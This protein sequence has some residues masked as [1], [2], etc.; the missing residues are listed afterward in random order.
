MLAVA[1]RLVPVR[2]RADWRRE[3]TSELICTNRRGLLRRTLPCF[4]DALEIRRLELQEGQPA[5]QT[6]GSRRSL[7]FGWDP[8][9]STQRAARSLL[10]NPVF[11]I[12][13]VV[14]LGLGIGANTAIF[15]FINAVALKPPAVDDPGRLVRIYTSTP[16]GQPYGPTSFVELADIVEQTDVFDGVVGYALAAGAHTEEGRIELLLGEM[17][18][19]NYFDVL[20]AKIAMGRAFLPE[21]YE[22]AG[23]HPVIVLGNGLW[24]RRFGEDPTMVGQTIRLNGVS[25]DIIGVADESYRGMLPGLWV[26]F[27]APSMMVRTLVPDAPDALTS[28]ESRQFMVHARLRDGVTVEEAQAAVGLVAA[29]LE[30]TFPESNAGHSMTVLKADSVRVHPRIDAVLLPIALLALV[31]PGLVL[32]IACTNLAGLLLARAAD[33]RKEIAVRL[34]L[35][36]RRR[37]IVLHLLGESVLLSL[38]GGVLG[39]LLATWLVSLITSFTPP[40]IVSLSLDVGV[41]HRVLVFTAGLS[42]LVGILFGLVPAL[43]A[44]KPEL[45]RALKDEEAVVWRARRL[46]LRNALIV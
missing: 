36:A 13:A 17:V 41:D 4:S 37:N 1:A 12:T 35:G 27:W 26:D 29:R 3:W 6:F 40:V 33:R 44:S 9:R 8:W 45:T 7:R 11:S 31:V 2:R 42:V 14:T 22:T 20:G 43:R 16:E 46:S 10:Q 38:V 24:V 21:E 19:G 18:T 5:G 15:S 32:L 25:F 28:R 39:I 34:A 23:T 30:E